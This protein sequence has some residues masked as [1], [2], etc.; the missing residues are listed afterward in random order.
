MLPFERIFAS[1]PD[2]ISRDEFLEY[3]CISAKYFGIQ[4]DVLLTC[5]VKAIF[6][7]P[8]FSAMSITFLIVRSESE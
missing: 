8:L 3:I 6:L 1:N 5:S 7:K 2:I 4:S